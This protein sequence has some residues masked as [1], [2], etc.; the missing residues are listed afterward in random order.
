M[1]LIAAVYNA[2]IGMRK[3]TWASGMTVKKGEIVKSPAD[4]ED[5]ERIAATGGG[6]TD[7]ADDVANY[8]AR[9]Y[10]RTV[11]LPNVLSATTS[12]FHGCQRST[13]GAMTVAGGRTSM[14]SVLGRGSVSVLGVAPLAN[15]STIRIEVFCD[16][17]SIFDKTQS[18]SNVNQAHGIIGFPDGYATVG[19]ADVLQPAEPAIVFKRSFQ[20]FWTVTGAD[21]FPGGAIAYNIRSEA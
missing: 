9:S 13:L 15:G 2:V 3:R 12:L 4:N 8:V 20:L 5:Y 21:T 1:S 7:P 11:A 10:V 16:G 18:Y 19:N 14:L 6:T 17:R